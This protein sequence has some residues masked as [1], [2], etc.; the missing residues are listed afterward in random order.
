MKEISGGLPLKVMSCIKHFLT[1]WAEV[2]NPEYTEAGCIICTLLQY[3]PLELLFKRE[4]ERLPALDHYITKL[5]DFV[6][7]MHKTS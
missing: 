3:R 2:N 5:Q 7:L 4:S 6:F 1:E